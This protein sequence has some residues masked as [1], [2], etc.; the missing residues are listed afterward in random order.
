[1]LSLGVV[2]AFNYLI[3]VDVIMLGTPGFVSYKE[4]FTKIDKEK[5]LKEA[6]VV[7]GGYL[8]LGFCLYRVRFEI[9]EKD[10]NSSIIK[11]D[12]EYEVEDESA[13]NA[14]LVT[15]KPL[16]MIAE[17]IGKYLTEKKANNCSS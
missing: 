6:E 8:E 9:V 4:K 3:V 2:F 12:I 10:A 14:A 16:E 11:S 13:S 1:M 7:E 15:T 5:R 17:A